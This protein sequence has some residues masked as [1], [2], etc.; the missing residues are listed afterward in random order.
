MAALSGRQKE[1]ADRLSKLDLPGHEERQARVASSMRRAKDDLDSG[2]PHDLVPSQQ[3]ARRELERLEQAIAG[4]T[5]IDEQVDRL[6]KRQREIADRLQKNSG[7]PDPK[8]TRNCN[9]FSPSLLTTC[10][11]CRPRRRPPAATTP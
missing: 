6:A 9:G 11:S 7:Q 3:A 5:P 8:R 4:Q 2:R 1:A 10:R